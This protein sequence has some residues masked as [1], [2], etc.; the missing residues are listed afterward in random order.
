MYTQA[1]RIQIKSSVM[2]TVEEV[3]EA[4]V[5]KTITEDS[6]VVQT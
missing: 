5:T 6:P 2:D 4:Q 3:P 1:R